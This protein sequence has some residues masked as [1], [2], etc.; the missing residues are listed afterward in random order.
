MS[1]CV[2]VCVCVCVRARAR[3][4]LGWGLG[5]HECTYVI[6]SKTRILDCTLEEIKKPNIAGNKSAI[7]TRHYNKYGMTMSLCI[8]ESIHSKAAN[9]I[10]S[11]LPPITAQGKLMAALPMHLV[12]S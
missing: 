5:M 1:V 2:C 4:L 9:P 7:I 12:K 6:Y 11:L 10:A 3:A 8:F